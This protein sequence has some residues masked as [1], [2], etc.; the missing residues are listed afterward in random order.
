MLTARR[1]PDSSAR[2]TSWRQNSFQRSDGSGPSTSSTSPPGTDADHTPTVGHTIER[3]PSLIR[4]CGRIVAK[5]VNG[6]GSI[7]ATAVASHR[8]TRAR[9]DADAAS[10]ASFHPVN[11]N[12]TAGLR[13]VGS[14]SRRTCSMD[15]RLPVGPAGRDGERRGGRQREAPA[16]S[17]GPAAG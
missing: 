3:R 17:W 5:S 13:R 9:T 16:R 4:T 15:A 6:S 12:S 2:P 11:A 7:S 8:S 14:A 1:A 10:P